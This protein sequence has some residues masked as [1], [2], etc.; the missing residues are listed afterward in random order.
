MRPGA[1]EA[2]DGEP[3]C[4]YRYSPTPLQE[5]VTHG[6]VTAAGGTVNFFD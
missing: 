6:G 4:T 3:A 2:A 1:A 5:I